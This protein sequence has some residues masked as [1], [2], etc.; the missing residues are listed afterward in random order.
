MRQTM[1]AAMYEPVPE[2][3]PHSVTSWRQGTHT[4]WKAAG[5]GGDH[6]CPRCWSSWDRPGGTVTAPEP[7]LSGV[8]GAH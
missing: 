6:E 8:S 1:C 3:Y 2:G 5:H 7:D 4:C